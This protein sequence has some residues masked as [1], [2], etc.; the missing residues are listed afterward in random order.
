MLSMWAKAFGKANLSIHLYDRSSFPGGNICKHLLQ[1]IKPDIDLSTFDFSGNDDN[2]SLGL[3]GLELGR[4]SNK[5]NKKKR[6]DGKHNPHRG[7]VLHIIEES[8][9][10]KHG[11]LSWAGQRKVYTQ[12]LKSNQ[13][14]AR[15]FLGL[16]HS[17]FAPPA[18]SEQETD[19]AIPL[20]Q[21]LPVFEAVM[22]TYVKVLKQNASYTDSLRDLAIKLEDHPDFTLKDAKLLM[23]TARLF[24]P[25]GPLLNEKIN[26]YTAALAAA[27]SE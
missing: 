10:G 20:S 1:Q 15:E 23:E 12:F 18:D 9:I 17:P 14:F 27:D 7:A 6:P 2:V 25:Y 13:A 19:P 22:K 5:I 24:R 4:L 16:A 8:A 11:T 3:A 26:S 21:I